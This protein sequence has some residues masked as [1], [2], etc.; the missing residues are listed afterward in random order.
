MTTHWSSHWFWIML[1][2]C[3]TSLWFRSNFPTNYSKRFPKGTSS[4]EFNMIWKAMLIPSMGYIVGLILGLIVY[5][6]P[7]DYEQRNEQS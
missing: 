5:R 4:I 2:I 1:A 3:S 6:K 7:R